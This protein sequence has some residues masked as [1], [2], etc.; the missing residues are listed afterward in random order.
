MVNPN[1]ENK[2]YLFVLTTIK[3]KINI[4]KIRTNYHELHSETGRSTIP[5]TPWQEIICHVCDTNRVEDEK[6]FLLECS[7]YTQ[8]RSQFPNICHNTD[9]PDL[10]SHQNFSDLGTLLL[11][12]FKHRNNILKKSK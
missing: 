5:K 6:R 10:L 7:T 12:F 11:M 1:F 9:L 4:V 2:K 3:K 8:I